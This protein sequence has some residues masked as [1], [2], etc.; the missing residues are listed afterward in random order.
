[1]G[2][3]LVVVDH[4]L[5]KGDTIVVGEWFWVHNHMVIGFDH[6]ARHMHDTGRCGIVL[7]GDY[8]IVRGRT[9][10]SL[11]VTL[12]DTFDGKTPAGSRA[13]TGIVFE[14]S[15]SVVNAWPAARVATSR[16]ETRR[17]L[18]REKFCR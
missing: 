2:T 11:V 9:G 4:P 7:A 15:E 6:D 16:R 12:Q 17:K 8:L 18:L 13:P 3:D 5:K 10:D 1:M 14:L